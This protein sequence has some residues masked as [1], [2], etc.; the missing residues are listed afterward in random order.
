MAATSNKVLLC[1]INPGVE[2]ARSQ[3]HYSHHSNHFYKALALSGITSRLFLPSEDATFPSL[4]PYT[5]GL[6]N[7]ASRPTSQ[8][9][10]LG[11]E[12]LSAGAPILLGKIRSCRPRLVG[13]VGKGI[14]AAFSKA[15]G[16]ASKGGEARK[17]LVVRV[18]KETALAWQ[19]ESKSE[20]GYGLMKVCCLCPTVKAEGTAAED[21]SGGAGHEEK[22]VTLF[23]SGASTSA[24]VT[25]LQLP[26]KA[27]WFQRMR[28]LL[29]HLK[30]AGDTQLLAEDLVVSGEDGEAF[31]TVELEVI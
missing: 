29:D 1:G 15:V 5:I 3:H 13:F 7:L 31:K 24:R 28:G 21:A 27:R 23:W 17:T 8:A 30:A 9:T 20:A 16:D 25:S 11:K 19:P 10:E 12:E 2:S 18:P 14:A 4:S 26:D 22:R 6:T